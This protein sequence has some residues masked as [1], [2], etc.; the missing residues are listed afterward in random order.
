MR[1]GLSPRLY[2]YSRVGGCPTCSTCAC[3]IRWMSE[4]VGTK[5]FWPVF[6][7]ES[8]NAEWRNAWTPPRGPEDLSPAV[9]GH[10]RTHLLLAA[11]PPSRWSKRAETRPP[12]LRLKMCVQ[13]ADW[14]G[15]FGWVACASPGAG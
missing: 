1:E 2:S 4:E 13:C 10:R 8:A 14:L 3:L 9:G 15:G 5:R 6:L 12:S 7:A 11:L